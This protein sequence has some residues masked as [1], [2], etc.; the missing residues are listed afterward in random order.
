M[1]AVLAPN[2]IITCEN[3]HYICTTNHELEARNDRPM[4]SSSWFDR[5]AFGQYVPQPGD[6]LPRFVS[7]MSAGHRGLLKDLG[8]YQMELG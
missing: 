7:V 2:T 3:G 5:F 8:L 1:T 6:Y 4:V